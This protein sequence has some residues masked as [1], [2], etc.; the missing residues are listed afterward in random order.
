MFWADQVGLKT[1]KTRMLE[2]ERQHGAVWQPTPLLVR[3]AD[4]GKGFVDQ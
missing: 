2:F 3:L 1:L 4:V